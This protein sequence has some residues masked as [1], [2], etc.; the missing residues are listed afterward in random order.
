MLSEKRINDL[1]EAGWHGLETGFDESAFQNWRREAFKCL[2][3]MMGPEHPYT[4]YFKEYVHHY[5]RAGLLAGGGILS[6]AKEE[7]AHGGN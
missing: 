4:L 3:A 5:R 1:I 6:A 7:L 2:T